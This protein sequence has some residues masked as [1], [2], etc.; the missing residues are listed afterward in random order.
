MLTNGC[1]YSLVSV[2]FD[3]SKSASH[4]VLY[5]RA[6]IPWCNHILMHMLFLDNTPHA[7]HRHNLFVYV[8]SLGV[9]SN[10]HAPY[11]AFCMMHPCTMVHA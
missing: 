4:T 6:F 10:M 1:Q 3:N 5:A 8:L 7:S 2:W 11:H 9:Q